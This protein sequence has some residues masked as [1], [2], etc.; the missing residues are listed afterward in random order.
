MA[1]TEKHIFH[2]FEKARWAEAQARGEY[3]P[4]AF[5]KEGFIHFSSKHQLKA[6]AERYYK[7]QAGL[8]VLK[9]EVGRLKAPLRYENLTGGEELFPHL[10]GPL[11]LDAVTQ[12]VLLGLTHEGAFLWSDDLF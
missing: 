12:I 10:Y 2:I 4:E 8:G 5:E 7:G 9:V 1:K 6:T 3:F 11:N